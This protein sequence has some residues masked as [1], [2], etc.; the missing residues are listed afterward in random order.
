MMH[1]TFVP[2]EP[3][4]LSAE[5]DLFG[6]RDYAAMLE[7]AVLAA[8]TRFTFGLFGDW[9]LG[10]STILEALRERLAERGIA[11]SSASTPGATR[12]T[13]SAASSCGSWRPNSTRA[14]PSGGGSPTESSAS[15]TK[16]SPRRANAS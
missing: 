6:H 8:P 10:K 4:S 11:R 9:G 13:L 16:T 7:R 12:T 5:D 15:S 1:P 2:D 3:D 14:V